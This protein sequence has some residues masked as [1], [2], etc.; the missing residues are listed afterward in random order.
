MDERAKRRVT[1]VAT[2]AVLLISAIFAEAMSPEWLEESALRPPWLAAISGAVFFGGGFCH[3]FYEA[4]SLLLYKLGKETT[5]VP[6]PIYYEDTRVEFSPR[7]RLF[8]GYPLSAC[9]AFV[10]I[11]VWTHV[12][13]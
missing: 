8:V 12:F 13:D 6:T 5:F 9:L 1:V 10:G 2:F 4:L 11:L 3:L 7:E